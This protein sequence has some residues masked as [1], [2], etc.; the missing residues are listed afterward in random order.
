MDGYA[1]DREI[2]DLVNAFVATMQ[3]LEDAAK[4]YIEARDR[5]AES[6]MTFTSQ[7]DQQL[8]IGRKLHLLIMERIKIF[9]Q[10]RLQ[11]GT[12]AAAQPPV[13]Q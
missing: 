4:T 5:F 3:P 12:I 9:E 7:F 8:E 6:Y 2:G 11:L 10:Q 1:L 13:L